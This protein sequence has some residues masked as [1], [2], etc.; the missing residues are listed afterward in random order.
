MANKLQILI[1]LLVFSFGINK[2]NSA[3]FEFEKVD[4]EVTGQYMPL[5][6]EANVK[7][8]GH[9][10][11]SSATD[12]NLKVRISPIVIAQNAEFQICTPGNCFP[13]S[14][15]KY[16]TT[17]GF[18]INSKSGDKQ[19]EYDIALIYT[20]ENSTASDTTKL[21]VTV[22]EDNNES[23][24]ISYTLT[25]VISKTGSVCYWQQKASVS[26]NPAVNFISIKLNDE[27]NSGN[28]NNT[29]IIR[30]YNEAGN[31]VSTVEFIGNTYYYT[32]VNLPNGRYFFNIESAG[33]IINSGNFVVAK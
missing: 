3:N 19:R 9:L 25:Y 15:T 5:D 17:T 27:C 20:Y 31:A 11:T 16:T 6:P 22:F 29:N 7:A 12:I 18:K 13:P 2:A 23:N 21:D 8:Y 24:Q 32:T 1:I 4:K 26:P 14:T 30:I 33:S 28:D 10:K